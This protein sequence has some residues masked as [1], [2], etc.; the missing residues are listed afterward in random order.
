MQF[1]LAPLEFNA[2][3]DLVV[4]QDSA[5]HPVIHRAQRLVQPPRYLRFADIHLGGRASVARLNSFLGRRHN[6][7]RFRFWVAGAA[8]TVPTGVLKIAEIDKKR[9]LAVTLT[10]FPE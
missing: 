6:F 1:D 3:P 8:R 10:P 4:G 9:G 5:L 2:P 7:F